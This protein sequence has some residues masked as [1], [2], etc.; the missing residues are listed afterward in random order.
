MLQFMGARVGRASAALAVVAALAWSP[1]ARAAEEI[2]IGF[3][4]ALTG[5][6]AAVGK[7]ALLAMQM[8]RDDVNAKG[9]LL[10]KPVKL[11]WY[12]DQSQPSTVP[13]I[14]TKLMDVDKVDFVVSGY[15]TNQVAPAIPVVMNANKVFLGLFA[16]DANGEFHYPK[17]FSMLPTGSDPKIAFSKGFIDAAMKLNPKPKTLAIIGADAEFPKNAIDGIRV[18]AKQ[19]GLNIVYDKTYPPPTTDFTPIVRAIQAANADIV[20]IASYPPD[21][22][23]MVRATNEV[24]LKAQLIGGG[25]V[26]LQITAIKTQLG[27]LLNG[28][29]SYD[30]WVPTDKMKA[31]PGIPEFL[32]K[33]QAKAPGE[34]VDPL[35]Y[36]LPI[37]AYSYLQVLG[38][39][40]A[41]T[42]SM[43][44]DKVA[45]YIRINSFKTLAGDIRFGKNGEWEK[46]RVLMVQYQNIKGNDLE[47]FRTI[48][49]EVVF[50]PPEYKTGD[51]K[52]PFVP[53]GKK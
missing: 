8:W 48:G 16:L 11:I 34:G 4:M 43:D 5:G 47:Q 1:A 50:D 35:G 53:E 15:A 2:T 17:Y 38:D 13:G 39:A 9:G 19:A 36:Y 51:V 21:S 52:A 46:P 6:L 31:F 23:G 40:V 20:Y 44:Q 42:K 41:A 26:G 24:G 22:V 37:F 25:M 30:W 27:P 12:D 45:D 29:T 49:H 28:F 18:N 32:Q 3:G 33:Y 7:T 14:Y 10:G